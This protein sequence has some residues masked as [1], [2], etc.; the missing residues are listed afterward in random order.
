M[1]G[2]SRYAAEGHPKTRVRSLEVELLFRCRTASRAEDNAYRAFVSTTDRRPETMSALLDAYNERVRTVQRL[3][4]QRK[5]ANLCAL[6]R[7]RHRL[8]LVEQRRG[9]DAYEL[10]NGQLLTDLL[11]LDDTTTTHDDIRPDYDDTEQRSSVL[12]D[13]VTVDDV[14]AHAPPRPLDRHSHTPGGSPP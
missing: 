6:R 10:R 8:S 3:R 7:T 5:T 12:L 11:S 4:A 1:S 9:L 2:A 13:E 14:G